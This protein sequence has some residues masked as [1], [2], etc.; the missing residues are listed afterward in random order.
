M[1]PPFRLSAVIDKIDYKTLQAQKSK[2]RLW[3]VLL[4]GGEIWV[5]RPLIYELRERE[6]GYRDTHG[7]DGM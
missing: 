4:N 1:D 6:M 5:Y 7:N 2:S 3:A